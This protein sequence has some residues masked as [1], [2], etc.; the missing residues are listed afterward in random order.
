MSFLNIQNPVSIAEDMRQFFLNKNV[1]DFA[2]ST[3]FGQTFYPVILSI[4]NQLI[5]PTLSVIFFK[6]NTKNL[7][8]FNLLG[9]QIMFGEVLN[10]LFIFFIS[11]LILYFTF[12]I[13]L[14]LSI[15]KQEEEK[16]RSQEKN[17][18]LFEKV[19]KNIEKINENSIKILKSEKKQERYS[20]NAFN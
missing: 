10:N 12:I 19:V 5:V 1:A 14:S 17:Q 6:I 9:E 4:V 11:M 7:F 18:K 2:I 3:V 13:P 8:K 20:V 15:K 16:Q